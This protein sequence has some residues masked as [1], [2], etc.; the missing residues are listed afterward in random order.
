MT[1]REKYALRLQLTAH[2]R[3][4]PAGLIAVL[5]TFLQEVSKTRDDYAPGQQPV[6]DPQFSE[7]LQRVFDE[8]SDVFGAL[9]GKSGMNRR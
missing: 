7:S 8:Y 2:Y 3:T 6:S 1:D 5:R 9:A 4:D